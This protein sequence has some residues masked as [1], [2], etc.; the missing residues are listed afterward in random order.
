[1]TIHEVQESVEK[2]VGSGVRNAALNGPCSKDMKLRKA[3]ADFEGIMLQ[4][5][6]ESMQKTVGE[7]GVFGDSPQKRMYESMFIQE[8][9]A[10]LAR[11][12]SLGFGDALYRQLKGKCDATQAV[13]G[14]SKD[15]EA[16]ESFPVNRYE[17]KR[18]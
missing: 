11:E 18:S 13:S 14:V 5:M 12:K 16:K 6:L 2:Q 1:M 8:I 4:Y 7:G 17:S 10:T 9:S 15:G 3:C